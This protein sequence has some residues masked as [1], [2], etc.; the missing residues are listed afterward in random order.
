MNRG[1]EAPT[2]KW[3]HQPDPNPV[4]LLSDW[5]ITMAEM[6]LFDLVNDARLH[7]ENYPPD[8]SQPSPNGTQPKMTACPKAFVESDT[9][10]DAA[11]QHNKFTATQTADWILATDASGKSLDNMHRTPT[12]PGGTPILDWE[13][14][15][16]PPPEQGPGIIYLAGYHSDTAENWSTFPTPLEVVQNWMIDDA[17]ADWGHRNNILNC[18]LVEAG[19]GHLNPT[20][21]TPFPDLWTLCMGTK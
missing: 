1:P 17:S 2:H 7:P 11:R 13:F 15:N 14:P 19:V 20:N 10:R 18:A 4:H 21:G 5:S 12:A 8:T 3:F 6:S 16:P 9:L